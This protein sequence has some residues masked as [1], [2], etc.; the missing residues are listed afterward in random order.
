MAEFPATAGQE[1]GGPRLA[2]DNTADQASLAAE[3]E[4]AHTAYRV[5]R[6]ERL[7]AERRVVE[8]LERIAIVNE[9]YQSARKR[10]PG[11]A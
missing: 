2:V 7:R 3:R 1:P 10:R 9:A 6:I 4:A 8:A 11:C 5:A